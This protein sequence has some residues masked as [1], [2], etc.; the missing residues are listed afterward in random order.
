MAFDVRIGEFSLQRGFGGFAVRH[1][2]APVNHRIFSVFVVVVFVRLSGVVRRIGNHD[3]DGRFFLSADAFGILLVEEAEFILIGFRSLKCVHQTNAF[4][5]F[6]LSSGLV[7]SVLDVHR[8]DVIREQ[9]DFVAM[10]FVRELVRQRGFRNV[11]HEIDNEIAGTGEGVEDVNVFVGESF[12]EFLFQ[13]RF[14][15]GNHEVHERLRRVNDAVRVGYLDTKA[16]KE[17]FTDGVEEC[18]LLSE[19][20]NSGGG[21]FDCA[22]EMFQAFAEIVAAEHTGIESSDDLFN[23]L[24][25][26]VA[27]NEVGDVENFA[28]D[29]FSEDVL[30]NHLLNGFDGNVRI[31][32]ATAEGTETFEGGD[33]LLIGL[34]FGFNELFQTRADLRDS[35]LEFDDGFFPI[36]NG[37]WSEFEEQFENVNEVVGL[38]QISFEGAL[39]LLIK[40]GLERF[41]KENIV[42]R[43]ASG[44]L[45]FDFFSRSSLLSLASQM[46]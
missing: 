21:V 39:S 40:H 34:A 33:E 26:D 17:T 45:C 46:P 14:D 5:R 18:L 16:L 1:A 13:H 35:V 23:F 29:A 4:K 11:P 12:I 20:R 7:I 32:R 44:K 10:Q 38:G 30:D 2:N 19:V 24:R 43:I 15:A 41:L 42:T 31:E 6:I 25:D 22:V 9:H 27:R 37:R 28:K 8:G 36:G 3:A